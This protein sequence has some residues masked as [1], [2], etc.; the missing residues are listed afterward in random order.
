MGV[1]R[2]GVT[3]M[4]VTRMGM[5]QLDRGVTHTSSAGARATHASG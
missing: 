2:M 3:R 4:G 5:S 1:T